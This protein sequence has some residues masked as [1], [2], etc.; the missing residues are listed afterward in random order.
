[1]VGWCVVCVSG[2]MKGLRL[3]RGWFLFLF[4]EVRVCV[5]GCCE[6]VAGWALVLWGLRSAD[7]GLRYVVFG[8]RYVVCGAW[9]VVCGVWRVMIGV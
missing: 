1:M 8:A 7:C 3:R 5:W 2:G 4:S 9:S 6:R